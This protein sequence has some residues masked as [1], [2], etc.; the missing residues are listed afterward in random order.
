M[1]SHLRAHIV[2]KLGNLSLTEISTKAVQSF[3]TY[4]ASEGRSRKTVENVLMSLSSL[5]KTA[6]SWSYAC[7][8][9]RYADLTLPRYG[10]KKEARYFTDEEAGRIIAAAQEP[11]K[12]IFTIASVLGLRIG[13]VLALRVCDL[14]FTQKIIRIRQSVDAATRKIQAVKSKSSNADLPTSAE[15]EARLRDYLLQ[16]H[17][18]KADLLF[19]NRR[20]RPFSANKLREKTLHPLLDRLG[21][22]RGGFHSARHGASTALIAD[23][24]NPA[25]VQKQLRHSDPRI[26]LSIYSHVI[27]RQHRDAVQNRSTRVEKYAV[28]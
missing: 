19:L 11:F 14:D 18:G 3:V 10:V 25:I 21:I 22:P 24:V 17:D 27:D 20:G 15:L 26:T 9:F 7:G 2:P 4:L 28:N 23:G 5:L 8:N 16:H 12:T 1:E 13:E 6:R